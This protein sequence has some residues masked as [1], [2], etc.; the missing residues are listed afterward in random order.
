MAEFVPI[1]LGSARPAQDAELE[2]NSLCGDTSLNV[3]P[4]PG[5]GKNHFVDAEGARHGGD[6]LMGGPGYAT[7]C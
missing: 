5:P 4:G 3:I 2:K 7:I 1:Y 6:A